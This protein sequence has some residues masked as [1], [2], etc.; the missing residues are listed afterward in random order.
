MTAFDR[1]LAERQDELDWLYMELYDDREEL[2]RLKERMAD[3][4]G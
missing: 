4:Y 3:C 1:R 2:G